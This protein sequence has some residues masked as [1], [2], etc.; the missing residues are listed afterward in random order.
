[1]EIFNIYNVLKRLNVPYRETTTENIDIICPFHADKSYGSCKINSTTGVGHCFACKEGFNAIKLVR[2]INKC[3]Y[4]DALEFLNIPNTYFKQSI[5][6]IKDYEFESETPSK[7]LEHKDY[8]RLNL[9]DLNPESILYTRN[10]KMTYEFFRKFNVKVCTDGFYKDYLIFPIIDTINNVYSYEA[11]K[12]KEYE[13]LKGFLGISNKVSI[14]RLRKQFERFI[15]QNNVKLKDNRDVYVNGELKDHAE[16]IKYLLL[17]KTLYPKGSLLGKPT[18]WN[19]VNLD[20]TKELFICEGLGSV[21]RIYSELSSN[22][23]CSFGSIIS[24]KQMEL[25]NEF[26]TIIIIKDNDSAGQSYVDQFRKNCLAEILIANTKLEDTDEMFI[27]EIKNKPYL[28]TI[29]KV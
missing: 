23:T 16:L 3:S 13:Y 9:A 20:R 14:V 6:D 27:E 25:L 1:M 7:K 12:V 26:K 17:P 5:L 28:Y 18:I 8:S 19:Y 11:R 15:E 29:D 22:V 4:T 21:P 10:R 24:E 2:Y